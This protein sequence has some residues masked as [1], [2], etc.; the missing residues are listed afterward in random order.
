ME[1]KIDICKNELALSLSNN[2]CGI[3]SSYEMSQIMI[4][5]IEDNENKEMFFE[6]KIMEVEFSKIDEELREENKAQ[7]EK[8]KTEIVYILSKNDCRLESN[9][10]MSHAY[11]FDKYGN[12]SKINNQY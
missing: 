2:E 4:Y 11:I 9:Y 10:D 6:P 5:L 12:R 8:A 1:N 3:S 7:F